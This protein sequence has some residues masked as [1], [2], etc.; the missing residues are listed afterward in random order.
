MVSMLPPLLKYA[1]RVDC[2]ADVREEVLG[3]QLSSWLFTPYFVG[4]IEGRVGRD[5][6]PF[7]PVVY[8]VL[9][10][11]ASGE[12]GCPAGR[13]NGS[14]HEEVLKPYAGGGKT[15]TTEGSA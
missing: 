4:E 13:A 10:S 2:W 3:G 6:A 1:E 5:A 8:A 15:T 11:D 7:Y 12:E 14:G 9:R